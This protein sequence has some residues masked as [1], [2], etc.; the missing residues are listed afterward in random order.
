MSTASIERPRGGKRAG[1]SPG[2]VVEDGAARPV[3][4]G[5]GVEQDI[6]RHGRVDVEQE[7]LDHRE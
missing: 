4:D 7:Q 5:R 1:R 3:R 2:Q 6:R